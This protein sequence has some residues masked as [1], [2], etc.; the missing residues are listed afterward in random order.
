VSVL[1]VVAAAEEEEEEQEQVEE[2]EQEQE[3]EQEEEEGEEQEEQ[4]EE[5]IEGASEAAALLDGGLI[6]KEEYE[7][8]LKVAE[9]A[10]VLSAEVDAAG[11]GVRVGSGLVEGARAAEQRGKGVGE[12]E[13]GVGEQEKEEGTQGGD[14]TGVCSSCQRKQSKQAWEFEFDDPLVVL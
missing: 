2:Q 4:E 5:K 7:R 3:Q 13:D 10:R 9:E 1:V 11:Q 8:L 12:Q 6:N 14:A